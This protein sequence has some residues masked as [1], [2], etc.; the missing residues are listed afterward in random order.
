MYKFLLTLIFIQA[1]SLNASA[2]S[3]SLKVDK[4]IEYESQLGLN[5]SKSNLNPQSESNFGDINIEKD[6]KSVLPVVLSVSFLLMSL[7]GDNPD[8]SMYRALG[9]TATVASFSWY[10]D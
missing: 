6:D 7:Y 10:F 9:A 5:T 1:L 8:S 4:G 2:G 3:L